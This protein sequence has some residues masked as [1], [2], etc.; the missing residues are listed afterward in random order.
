MASDGWTRVK[1]TEAGQITAILGW[2]AAPENPPPGHAPRAYFDALRAAGRDADA[3]EFLSQALPRWEAVAWAARAVR[4]LG[5]PAD[6]AD[7][8]A[9]K[10]A[11]LWV[12]DPTEDRRRAAQTA[13]ED[14]EPD[15][16]ARLAA[17]AAFYSGGSMSPPEAEI[18]PAPRDAAGRFAAGAILTAAARA[19]DMDAALAASLGAGSAIAAGQV[20]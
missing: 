5:A 14:A 12:Q 4:D 17:L 19:A 20:T 3:V 15:S 2:K 1:W 10:A 11:L 9:L 6:E 13:A 7:A 18:L 16:P 8:R